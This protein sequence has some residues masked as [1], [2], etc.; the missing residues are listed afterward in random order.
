VAARHKVLIAVGISS[1]MEVV[2]LC[3]GDGWFTLEIAKLARSV[4]AIDTACARAIS[5]ECPTPAGCWT[6]RAR[7][8]SDLDRGA[9]WSCSTGF[10]DMRG[11]TRLPC[12]C[13]SEGRYRAEAGVSSEG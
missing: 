4:V 11:S 5:R 2:D 13:R 10:A 3:S 8:V 6:L 7:P 1:D 9:G 12:A